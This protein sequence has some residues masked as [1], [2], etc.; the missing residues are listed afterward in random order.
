MDFVHVAVLKNDFWQWVEDSG[1][2]A[3][4]RGARGERHNVFPGANWLIDEQS[5]THTHTLTHVFI[6]NK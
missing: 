2:V 1:E 6:I 5:N 3:E 4:G